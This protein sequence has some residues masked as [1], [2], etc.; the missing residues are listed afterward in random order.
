MK[1]PHL[2]CR[3]CRWWQEGLPASA[4][5][6]RSPAPSADWGACQISPPQVV[7]GVSA[8]VPL[9]PQTHAERFCGSWAGLTAGSDSD[10]PNDGEHVNVVPLRGVA[11]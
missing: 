1:P 3:T 11:A 5:M 6:L 7:S 10:G 2:S 4:T 9:W 8:A